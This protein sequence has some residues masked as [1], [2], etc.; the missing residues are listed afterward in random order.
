MKSPITLVVP[1]SK[2]GKEDF[3][4]SVSKKDGMSIS[5]QRGPN[6]SANRNAGIRKS[7]TPFVAFINGHSLLAPD[8]HS[9]V[10]SFFKEHPQVDVVGGPEVN[11][12]EDNFFG[13]ISG[14]ALASPFGSGGI[15]GRYGGKDLIMD[16]SE[17]QLTSANLIC[18]RKV[19]P[20]RSRSW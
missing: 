9:K 8:W 17:T 15:A 19:P 4:K 5:V 3:L 10:I 11:S 7:K 14:Y 16:A 2:E 1:L 12:K 6:P 13:R 18:R 20:T